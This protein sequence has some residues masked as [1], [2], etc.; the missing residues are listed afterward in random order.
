MPES[1]YETWARVL[2]EKV[3]E[4][5]L[6]RGVLSQVT[7]M[8]LDPSTTKSSIYTYILE[9]YR[10]HEED[11]RPNKIEPDPPPASAFGLK[12]L[13]ACG[14]E[15]PDGYREGDKCMKCNGNIVAVP[16]DF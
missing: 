5:K 8:A 13:C 15:A 1:I 9:Q 11:A 4:A 6:L 7:S 16:D 14:W 3:E 10:E 2:N 12:L